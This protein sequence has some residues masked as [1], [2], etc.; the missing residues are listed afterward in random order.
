M[1]IIGLVAAG[2]EYSTGC[3][4]RYLYPQSFYGFGSKEVSQTWDR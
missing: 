3:K 1:S 2:G 4:P